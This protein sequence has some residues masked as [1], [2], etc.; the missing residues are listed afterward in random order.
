MFSDVITRSFIRGFPTV[1]NH[2]IMKMIHGKHCLISDSA[3]SQGWGTILQVMVKNKAVIVRKWRLGLVL[4]GQSLCGGWVCCRAAA[5]DLKQSVDCMGGYDSIC[6]QLLQGFS[7]QTSATV[8]R[9]D[10]STSWL[11][12]DPSHLGF[13]HTPELNMNK[14]HPWMR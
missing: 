11:C 9:G 13:P 4:G 5:L 6:V 2:S 3:V 14:Y 7:C 10:K 8:Y 12:I 1:P